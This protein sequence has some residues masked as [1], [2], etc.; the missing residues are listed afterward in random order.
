MSAP[1]F[2]PRQGVRLAAHVLPAVPPMPRVDIYPTHHHAGFALR[3]GF[4]LPFGAIVLPRGVN[5]SVYSRHAYACTLV[6]FEPGVMAP[7]AEIPETRVSPRRP[8]ARRVQARPRRVK[9]ARLS[10][11]RAPRAGSIN[12]PSPSRRSISAR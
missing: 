1:V 3:P 11:A 12:Q 5:F 9:T 2:L 7:V 10:R 8:D 4:P 6:L